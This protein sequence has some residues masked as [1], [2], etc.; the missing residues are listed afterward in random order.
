MYVEKIF[1]TIY[2][3]SEWINKPKWWYGFLTSLK[4]VKG[5]DQQTGM[6]CL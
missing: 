5:R 6:S 1:K 3:G 2:K 4:V